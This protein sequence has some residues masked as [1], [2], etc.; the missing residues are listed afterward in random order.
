MTTFGITGM[1]HG[2]GARIAPTLLLTMA[3]TLAH[4][5]PDEEGYFVN[6]NRPGGTSREPPLRR[7]IPDGAGNICLHHRRLSLS[8]T[9]LRD[10]SPPWNEDGAVWVVFS[11]AKAGIQN[12]IAVTGAAVSPAACRT[13][14]T[15]GVW[16]EVAIPCGETHPVGC[17]SL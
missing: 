17:Q 12:I 14:F 1:F 7:V 16:P 5:G 6:S 8:S 3:R 13:D 2:T 15:R 11:G 9:F 10:S 4:R